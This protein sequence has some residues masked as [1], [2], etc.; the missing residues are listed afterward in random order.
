MHLGVL[1]LRAAAPTGTSL[2]LQLPFGTLVER[3]LELHREDTGVGDLEV[4]VRQSAAPLVPWRRV[5]LGLALGAVAPTGGYVARSDAA[6]LPP[7]ASYLTLGRGTTWWLAEGDARTTVTPRVATFA[8]LSARGPL[9]R[10]RDGF[11]W[12]SEVRA[13]LGGQLARVRPWLGLLLSTDVV[14]RDGATEPDPFS[15]GR[16]DSASSGGWQWSLSPAVTFATA[17]PLAVV[18]G[19]RVPIASDVV[20]NQL[21]PELGGFVAVAYRQRVAARAAEV[22]PEAGTITVVDY[23]ATWCAPCAEIGRTL[24]AAAPGWPDVRIRKVDATA[25]ADAAL[26][27]IEIF[28]RSGAR[29]AILVGGDAARVVEVVETLRHA[30]RSP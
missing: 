28:D 29:K 7:E 16:I 13:T 18:A 3:S 21:V 4:R 15:G 22:R 6:N 23:W 30:G 27:R 8:Q 5:A 20:G 2:D 9:A 14:W 19:A 12:G 1:E 24:D 10:T 25:R 11:A 26:P 17:W